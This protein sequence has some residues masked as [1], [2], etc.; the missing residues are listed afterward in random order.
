MTMA[1]G[2]GL[3]EF[4]IEAELQQYYTRIK[5]E[6]KVIKLLHKTSYSKRFLEPTGTL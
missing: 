3:L 4:L 2:P 1:R 6:L 5:S